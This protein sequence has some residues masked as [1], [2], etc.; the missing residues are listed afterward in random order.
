MNY[1]LSTFGRPGT[2]ACP[3]PTTKAEADAYTSTCRD[4]EAQHDAA[5]RTWDRNAILVG[6]GVAVAAYFLFLRKK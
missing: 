6:G 2:F 5:L 3:A 4:L 1:L